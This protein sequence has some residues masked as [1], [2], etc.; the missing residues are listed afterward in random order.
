MVRPLRASVVVALLLTAGSSAA[1]DVT[2][3]R[4]FRGFTRGAASRELPQSTVVALHED[5]EGVIWI[6]TLDGVARVERGTVERL[7]PLPGAPLSGPFYAIVDRRDGGVLLAGNEALYAWDGRAWSR[8]DTPEPVI[9]VAE[10]GN[11]RLYAVDRQGSVW[12]LPSGGGMW[13]IAGGQEEPYGFVALASGSDGTIVAGG[14]QGVAVIADGRV[15]PFLGHTPPDAAVTVLRLSTDGSCWVGGDDGR[16]YALASGEAAWRAIELPEWDGGRIRSIGEDRRGRIW[17]GGDHGRV[18]RITADGRAERWTPLNG[19]RDAT[20]TSLLGDRTGSVWFGYN[21]I[22]LQQWIGEAWSH[23]TYWR[24]PDDTQ[25][26]YAFSV[27]PTAAGGYLVAVFSRGVWHWD[28]RELRTYG[29]DE[30]ITE[31]V[32][33]AIEPTPGVIWAGARFGLFESR[34][35][36]PFRRILRLPSGFVNALFRAPDGAWWA[37]TSTEGVLVQD[38]NGWRPHP[39]NAQLTDPNVRDVVWRPNGEIWLATGRGVTRL[40]AGGS[41]PLPVDLPEG[42]PSFA[43]ALLERA[44][45]EM[46]VGGAGGIGVF[47][48]GTWRAITTDDGLPGTTVYSL[49]EA[50]DGTVW[51][52]GSAGV[53]HLAEG[54]WT[55]Y[56]ASDGLIA[57]EC[58][59]HGLLVRPDGD[60]LVGTMSGLARFS[61]HPEPLPPAALRTFWR[62]SS[63]D[64]G[65]GVASLPPEERSLVLRWSAPWPRP[66]N[67]EYRTRI[68][69]LRPEWSAPQASSELR[70]ENLGTGRWDVEV[71]ARLPGTGSG[72]W[73]RPLVAS[74]VVA[75]YLWETGWARASAALAL[76]GVLALV[77]RFRTRRL[78]RRAAALER[79]VQEELARV[80]V[81]RGLLP[82]C[83]HCKKIRDDGGY[84]RQL[85][86]YIGSHSEADFSHGFCPECLVR[87]YPDYVGR[88]PPGPGDA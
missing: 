27:T 45:G 73:T 8:I 70:I 77:V 87:H 1:Q 67:V 46:W 6:A 40:A 43:Y 19:L 57:E 56:D 7:A 4:A 16:V 38:G 10:D 86:D 52:G 29:R 18:A 69:R 84:W 88:Q 5:R 12:T 66:V 71:E 60:V 42:A 74:F 55:V 59:T 48:N 14:R 79:R 20:V 68:P 36:G 37:A 80:K 47:A 35:G 82:I 13:E 33:F 65:L 61:P 75:P 22:G 2:P 50:E 24:D 49:A 9:S 63:I 23:R 62:E 85:E 21:G 72:G 39:L 30:G 41:G 83:A 28:G 3:V 11:G 54:R 26:V 53:G 81:L 58:N 78:A 32:R 76:A 44:N 64:P 25:S 17:V 15:G 31:D 34:G 51:A